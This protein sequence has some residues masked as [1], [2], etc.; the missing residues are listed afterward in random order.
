MRNCEIKLL[1]DCM[2]RE[3]I[4]MYMCR[5]EWCTEKDIPEPL[6][7]ASK[8]NDGIRRFSEAEVCSE[9]SNYTMDDR[10]TRNFNGKVV[11]HYAQSLSRL[12]KNQPMLDA[13]NS[14]NSKKGMSVSKESK[15]YKL[16]KLHR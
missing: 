10:I 8:R 12:P 2:P 4:P 16:S 1:G 15:L 14:I 6:I 9:Y 3:S 7:L 5:G 11:H 13:L